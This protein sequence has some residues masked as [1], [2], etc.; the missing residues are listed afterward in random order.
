MNVLKLTTGIAVAVTLILGAAH[1]E[2]QLQATPVKPQMKLQATSVAKPP[3][4]APGFTPVGQKLVQHEGKSWYEYTCARQ[5]I[6]NR[7]CNAD[8]EVTD[9]NDKF[10]S[11]PSDGVS[12]KS[13]LTM[14]YKCW[15]YVPVE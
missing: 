2:T 7:T 8:T 14:S 6:I 10:T 3:Q 4:C 1:A 12:K 11:L 13:K 5:E 15:N 9:I